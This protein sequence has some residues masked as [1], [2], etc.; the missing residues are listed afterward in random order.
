MV[1]I[2]K[3]EIGPNQKST[4]IDRFV[5]VLKVGWQEDNLCVWC[6]VSDNVRQSKLT[7]YILPTGYEFEFKEGMRYLDTIQD[8]IYVWHIFYEFWKDSGKRGEN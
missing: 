4:I 2:Y 8:G 6:L 3:Y 5:G 7:F 1:K